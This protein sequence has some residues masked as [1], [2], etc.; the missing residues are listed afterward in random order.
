MFNNIVYS[1][2]CHYLHTLITNLSSF[3]TIIIDLPNF[4]TIF[5]TNFGDPLGRFCKKRVRDRSYDLSKLEIPR[6]HYRLVLFLRHGRIFLENRPRE[7]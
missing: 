7:F 1:A 4:Y 2:V 5:I 3:C 6:A